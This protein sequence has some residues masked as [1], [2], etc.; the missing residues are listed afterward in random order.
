[1]QKSGRRPLSV[2]SLA[3]E[4][5]EGKQGEFEE[6]NTPIGSQ[7]HLIIN[8]NGEKTVQTPIPTH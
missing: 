3:T 8:N 1:M 2:T 4:D 6:L 7:K 5:E